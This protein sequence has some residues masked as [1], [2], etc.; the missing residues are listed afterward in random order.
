MG[1]VL[2][3]S[4]LLLTGTRGGYIAILAVAGWAVSFQLKP[5]L[6]CRVA[7]GVCRRNDCRSAAAGIFIGIGD[8]GLRLYALGEGDRDVGDLNGRLIVW[9]LAREAFDG[10]PML[11]LGAGTLPTL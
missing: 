6:P 7:E 2:A 11:G 10:H 8:K 3:Y 9:P 5:R 1:G 4:A